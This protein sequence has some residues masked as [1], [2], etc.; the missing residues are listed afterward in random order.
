MDNNE[1]KKLCL[2]LMNAKNSLEV[3][4]LLKS[5][6]LW[7]DK[8]LWKMYGNKEGSYGT[9]NSQGNA[10]FALTEKITNAD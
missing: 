6:N 5:K 4:E 9:A 7:D 3:V 1:I 8:S 2:D 10:L